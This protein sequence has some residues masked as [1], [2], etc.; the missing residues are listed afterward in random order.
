MNIPTLLRVSGFTIG[1]KKI[2]KQRC[3][4]TAALFAFFALLPMSALE[5]CSPLQ[6]AQRLL[7]RCRH[8][9][10][11]PPL[12]CAKASSGDVATGTLCGPGITRSTPAHG[13]IFRVVT[14][15]DKDKDPWLPKCYCK[16]HGMIE[17]H[18]TRSDVL[19]PI[20]KRVASVRSSPAQ[21][22]CNVNCKP[23]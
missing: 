20:H 19:L 2:K 10:L 6:L 8:G 14:L 17:L 1:S 13:C 21:L 23:L 11:V 3:Q 22:S 16:T 15:A 7:N 5:P 18:R 4:S 12:K 9:N